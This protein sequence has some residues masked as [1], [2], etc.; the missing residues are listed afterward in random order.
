MIIIFSG[1]RH[2]ISRVTVIAAVL[3]V[4]GASCGSK[5]T[6]SSSASTSASNT[7]TQAAAAT[8]N[9]DTYADQETR[10]FYL[11]F[12][13]TYLA[14][15]GYPYVDKD[16]RPRLYNLIYVNTIYEPD[17]MVNLTD[18]SGKWKDVYEFS[19]TESRIYM[20][21]GRSAGNAPIWQTFDILNATDVAAA[22]PSCSGT[23]YP[24]IGSL[25][26]TSYRCQPTDA[27]TQ[28][29]GSDPCWLPVD[30]TR[31]I[32]YRQYSTDGSATGSMCEVLKKNHIKSV[33]FQATL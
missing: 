7:N 9:T 16:Y 3:L 14:V 33:A 29:A 20:P 6:S 11:N 31:G 30:G 2:M 21:I 27:N 18:P 28:Y 19:T 12:K 8:T 24:L 1:M 22:L 10:T 32:L 5:T 4:V 15:T 26:A 25:T 23:P 13:D 17:D